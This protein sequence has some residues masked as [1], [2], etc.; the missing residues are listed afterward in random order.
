LQFQH[1]DAEFLRYRQRGR[2]AAVRHD[3]RLGIQVTEVELELVRAVGRV[4]R[5]SRA[6]T[7]YGNKSAGHLR[8]VGQDDGNP[9]AAANAEAIQGVGSTRDELVQA[10]ITQRNAGRCRHGDGIRRLLRDHFGQ[11]GE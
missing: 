11:G 2:T 7:G 4:Q 10:T 3:H 9:V 5:R 8:A 6:G 1:H